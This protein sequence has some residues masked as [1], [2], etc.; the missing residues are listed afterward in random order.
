MHYLHGRRQ[1]NIQIQVLSMMNPSKCPVH[2]SDPYML[3]FLPKPPSYTYQHA[4]DLTQ[5][6][7]LNITVVACTCYD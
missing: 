1:S 5:S 3:L 6:P 7:D 4:T 2:W